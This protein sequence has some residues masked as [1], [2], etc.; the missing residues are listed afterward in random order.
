MLSICIWVVQCS[1]PF[2]TAIPVGSNSSTKRY[3]KFYVRLYKHTQI[4]ALCARLSNREQHASC[5]GSRHRRFLTKRFTFLCARRMLLLLP[6]MLL[7]TTLER[8]VSGPNEGA[9]KEDISSPF[10]S[11][12]H[13]LQV[14][15]SSRDDNFFA[16]KMGNKVN[17]P[18]LARQ[19]WCELS[20][21]VCTGC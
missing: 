21:I 11:A 8:S 1:D 3:R 5:R 12:G 20:G 18:S 10:P 7:L 19:C 16:K 15:W 14:G 4:E 2:Q 6:L 13:C 17:V 9:E